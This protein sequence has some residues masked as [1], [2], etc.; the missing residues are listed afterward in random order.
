MHPFEFGI[1]DCLGIDQLALTPESDF[2]DLVIKGIDAKIN[3]LLRISV[4]LKLERADG[5][6]SIRVHDSIHPET[7]DIFY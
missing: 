6:V 2:G 3:L 5:D 1:F 4:D 7:K